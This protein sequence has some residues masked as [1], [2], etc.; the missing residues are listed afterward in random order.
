[1]QK[2]QQCAERD[3]EQDRPGLNAGMSFVLKMIFHYGQGALR[4]EQSRAVETC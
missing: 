4:D 3:T 1:M 2:G